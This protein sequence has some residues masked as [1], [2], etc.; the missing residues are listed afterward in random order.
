MFSLQSFC[1]S[2][3]TFVHMVLLIPVSRSYFFFLKKSSYK[4]HFN[5]IFKRINGYI[6]V[7]QS[8]EQPDF[9]SFNISRQQMPA[10]RIACRICSR[11]LWIPLYKKDKIYLCMY[12]DD[13]S[14]FSCY[15]F[16]YQPVLLWEE[17]AP[18]KE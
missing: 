13:Y 5:F 17:P 9:I 4:F 11:V 1:M 18:V 3:F 15:Y 16:Y 6:Y 8:S 7:I 14:R 12:H 10:I 2:K